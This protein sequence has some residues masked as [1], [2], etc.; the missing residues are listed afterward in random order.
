MIGTMME[1]AVVQLCGYVVVVVV[2][3]GG[4]VG[5]GVVRKYTRYVS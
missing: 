1:F 5:G 2:V 4:G 3:E